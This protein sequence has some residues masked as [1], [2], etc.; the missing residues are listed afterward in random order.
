MVLDKPIRI[1][2]DEQIFS[3]QR[4]GGISRY[5]TE[6][7]KGLQEMDGAIAKI[8]SPLCTNHYA[9][10]LPRSMRLGISAPVITGTEN[11]V[12]YFNKLLSY[13]CT[14]KFKPNILHQTYYPNRNGPDRHGV[15]IVTTVHDMIHELFPEDF[16]ESKEISKRKLR[17]INKADLVICVS[18]NTRKDLIRT[19]GI[20]RSKTTVIHHGV[21]H[22]LSQN[23]PAFTPRARPYLLY[24]GLRAAYKNFQRV[25][26]A[27]ASNSNLM[28]EFDLMCFGGGAL[29][30]YERG[31][32]AQLNIP[33]GKVI[34][35][36]GDDTVLSCL[37][38]NAAA[39]LYPSLY[40]GFG[41]PPLEAMLHGCPVI[42]SNI[43]SMP[44]VLG[45]AVEYFDPISTADLV[46][47]ITRIVNDPKR[48]Q[49]LKHLGM[50]QAQK[51]TWSKCAE[52]TLLSYERLF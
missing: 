27:Y 49:E 37:Y 36:K 24:V 42:S 1:L 19:T 26:K 20:K 44:E 25:L 5:Y 4:F 3:I 39:F 51:F 22:I 7:V 8:L 12:W 9:K 2:F 29:T 50:T 38:K 14:S 30:E 34:L 32:M 40:E 15:R 6:L 46:S 17:A 23:L 13:T 28:S 10:T 52:Q 33:E 48:S 16:P 11:F 45:H 18:E 35:T 47:A 31:L 21:D 41:I 43:S